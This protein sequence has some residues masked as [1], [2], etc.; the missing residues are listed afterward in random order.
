MSSPK[1]VIISSGLGQFSAN[2]PNAQAHFGPDAQAKVKALLASSIEKANQAGFDVVAVDANPQDPEDTL[3]RFSEALQSREAVGVNIGYGLR[4][5]K[6][7]TELF[8]KMINTACELRPGIKIMFSNGP[9]EVITA[10]KRS[11]PKD[12]VDESS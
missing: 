10:I 2:D 9:G 4:G 12:F 7:H 8:E 1:K 6:E 11:F 5:H 3:K